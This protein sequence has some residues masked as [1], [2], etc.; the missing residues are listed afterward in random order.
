VGV[1]ALLASDETSEVV[2]AQVSQGSKKH[3]A[4]GGELGLGVDFI[5][6]HRLMLGTKLSYNL[7]TDF[8][9]PFAG[10]KN[11]SSLELCVSVGYLF[12]RAFG[13]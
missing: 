10:R 3:G 8:S 4:F 5:L 2:A 11:F 1:G 12:G 6:A 13:T 9:E 7:L